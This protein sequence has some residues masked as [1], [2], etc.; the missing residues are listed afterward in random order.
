MYL[1]SIA[2]TGD[3]STIQKVYGKGN[4]TLT[5]EDLAKIHFKTGDDKVVKQ[6]HTSTR[7]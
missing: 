4:I 7:I 1:R 2:V 6:L 3:Y 5:V